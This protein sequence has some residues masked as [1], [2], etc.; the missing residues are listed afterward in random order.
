MLIGYFIF[1]FICLQEIS[2]NRLKFPTTQILENR[3]SQP[4][5][6]IIPEKVDLYGNPQPGG[7]VEEVKP[8]LEADVISNDKVVH[9]CP[10]SAK[11]T[12]VHNAGDNGG[13]T[14]KRK[15]N[16]LGIFDKK[17]TN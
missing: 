12:T 5:I 16:L 17:K 8:K 2:D 11:H 3:L 13:K 1:Y 4:N 6:C 10:H 7:L 15:H 9:T 14:K